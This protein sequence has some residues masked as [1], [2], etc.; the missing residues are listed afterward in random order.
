MADVL[1]LEVPVKAGLELGT[2]VGLDDQD[3]KWKS[4]DDLIDEANG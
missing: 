3:A 4:S 2:I 1:L